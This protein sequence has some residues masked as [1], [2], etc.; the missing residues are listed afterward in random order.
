MKSICKDIID[1]LNEGRGSFRKEEL[2]DGTTLISNKIESIFNRMDAP[3]RFFPHRPGYFFGDVIPSG[4]NISDNVSIRTYIR[5]AYL[6]YLSSKYNAIVR[7]TDTLIDESH[8][9]SIENDEVKI[10][11][12]YADDHNINDTRISLNSETTV[13]KIINTTILEANRYFGNKIRY[14]DINEFINQINTNYGNAVDSLK[15]VLESDAFAPIY[16]TGAIKT[17]FI[18]D[19]ISFDSSNY[20]KVIICTMDAS[21]IDTDMYNDISLEISNGICREINKG[22]PDE[23]ALSSEFNDRIISISIN[24]MEN[25]SES[26]DINN[27]WSRL[28]YGNSIYLESK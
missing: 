26:V 24:Y 19:R 22:L 3:D 21:Y 4:L 23:F 25:I 11:I 14:I 1:I 2:S 13:H 16:L 15:S 5:A 12:I 27:Q 8:R 28:L 18:E 17:S 7:S 20:D 9:D 10:G 6:D